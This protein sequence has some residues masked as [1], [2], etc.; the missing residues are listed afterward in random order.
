MINEIGA[1]ALAPAPAAHMPPG[2]KLGKDEFL[3]MLV[4]QMR[5]QDPL[6]PLQGEEMAAQLAQFSSLEQMTNV[7]QGIENLTEIIGGQMLHTMQA[8]S[9]LSVLGRTVVAAGDQVNIGATQK[10]VVTVDLASRGESATLR[11]L[12]A[13]GKEVAT[14][15]IGALAAGRQN[16][17]LGKAAEGL[18]PGVYRYKIDVVNGS[19][20]PVAVTT[21]VRAK[22]DSVR[23]GPNG[24]I[25]TAGGMTLPYGSIVEIATD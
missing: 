13:S 22:V 23:N 9:A 19:G 4:A 17:E 21:Y 20:D 3:K 11:I 16:I 18:P 7:N 1:S 5:N 8:T 24:P 14:R 12:D 6:N 25:L 15:E 2:G 10:P